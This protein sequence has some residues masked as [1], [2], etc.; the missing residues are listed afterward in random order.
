[1][2]KKLEQQIGYFTQSLDKFLADI[3]TIEIN[4]MVV[5]EIT[6]NR[7]ISWE[8]YRDIYLISGKYLAEIGI[9]DSLF[10]RYLRLRRDLEIEYVL[11][12]SDRQSEFYD[13][14]AA[15]SPL[16][17]H[18]NTVLEEIPSSLPSPI[19]QADSQA[20][21]KVQKILKYPQ[22]VVSLRRIS[23]LKNA[24]D[25]RN[26]KILESSNFQQQL[27]TDFLYAQTIIQL[28][29]NIVNQYSRHL[30]DHPYKETLLKFHQH[31]V[32]LGTKTWRELLVFIVQ[33]IHKW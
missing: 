9:H 24:L 27:T 3:T 4:T 15:N 33:L 22:F 5:D 32:E 23:E 26:K 21:F 29:G 12:A 13:P 19:E 1:M 25:K 2:S 11:I 20:I 10:E 8:S 28:D 17:S 6:E 18:H 7:F 30:F 16:L 14:N 31:G